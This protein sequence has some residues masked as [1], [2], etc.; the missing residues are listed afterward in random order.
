[1]NQK[2]LL[3]AWVVLFVLC[4]LMGLV[5]AA[6]V[7]RKTLMIALSLGFFVPPGMLIYQAVK[8][9]KRDKNTLRLVRN[10]SLLSLGLTTLVLILNFMSVMWSEAVG[11]G[12]YVLLVIV[13]SPMVCSQY[14]ALSLFAWACLLM[15]CLKYLRK[16]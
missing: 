13:S 7:T 15:V 1:M 14:W 16:K 12:L 2:K 4:A 3:R 6:T 5:P 8:Q 9:P 10:L 11:N